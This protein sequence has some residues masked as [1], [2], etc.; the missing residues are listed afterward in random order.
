MIRS[1]AALLLALPATALPAQLCTNR[2]TQLVPATIEPG[3]LQGCPGLPAWPYWHLLTPAHHEVVPKPGHREGSVRAVPRLLITWRCTGL[4]LAP[5][6]V[7]QVRT[8][9]EVYE[10]GEELCAPPRPPWPAITGVP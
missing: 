3:P 10:V 7:Q 9:G 4:L 8:M 6:A 1:T 5:V 2:G